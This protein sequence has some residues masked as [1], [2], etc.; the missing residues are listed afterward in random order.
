MALHSPNQQ[1][2]A[3]A[4]KFLDDAAGT[5]AALWREIQW[6]SPYHTTR[7][8]RN[9]YLVSK[10]RLVMSAIAAQDGPHL[11]DTSLVRVQ[12]Q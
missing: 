9:A 8:A 11:G 7:T 4:K 2:K 1:I 6:K 12:R 10:V 3:E 5:S